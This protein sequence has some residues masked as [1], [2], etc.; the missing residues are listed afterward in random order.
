MFLTTEPTI[1]GQR[2]TVLRVIY[3]VGVRGSLR[4]PA[5]SL[6]VAIG[7]ALAILEQ[8]AHQIGADAVVG[9][10]VS[11]SNMVLELGMNFCATAMGTAIKFDGQADSDDWDDWTEPLSESING[12]G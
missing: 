11:I 4:N 10:H 6:D 2:Y 12:Y 3:G 7:D 9:V 1:S 8:K 5:Y